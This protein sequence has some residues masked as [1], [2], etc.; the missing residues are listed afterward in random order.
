MEA[1]KVLTARFGQYFIYKETVNL[2][3]TLNISNAGAIKVKFRI[4]LI[5]LISSLKV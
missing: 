5:L 4:G 1:V 2:T 3:A